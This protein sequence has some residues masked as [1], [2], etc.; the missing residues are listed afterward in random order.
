MALL[1]SK[2]MR[3]DYHPISPFYGLGERGEVDKR[4]KAE[5]NAA[6]ISDHCCVC[7]V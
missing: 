6:G 5:I 3:V 1:L 4:G 7:I 2:E